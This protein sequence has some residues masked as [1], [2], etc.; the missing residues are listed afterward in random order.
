MKKLITLMAV[1]A[2]LGGPL[3]TDA[4]FAAPK[5]KADKSNNRDNE[6]SNR[7]HDKERPEK[8]N[9][10]VLIC[11]YTG[12][13]VLLDG[14]EMTWG[15]VIRVS[16]RAVEAHLAQGDELAPEG[17]AVGDDCFTVVEDDPAPGDDA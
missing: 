3:A 12:R 11:H 6:N 13:I 7:D 2:L 17:S 16:E 14:T 5:D 9:E 8:A 1:L 4:A 15:K 10:G